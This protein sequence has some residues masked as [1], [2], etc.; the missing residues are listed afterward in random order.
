VKGEKMKHRGVL[1]IC[2]IVVVLAII[3]GCA[4]VP[5]VKKPDWVIKGSGAFPGE[6][7]TKIYGVGVAGTDPNK[8]VQ[9]EQARAR[10]RAELAA[11]ITTTVQRLVKD[12]ME[13]H[14]DWF[15]LEDTAGSDEFF[16]YISKQVTD[17]TLVGSRQVDSWEDPKTG[18]LYMLY[19]VDMDNSFYDSYKKAL[20][21]ALSEKHRAVVIK[22]VNEA[23]AEL[24][25][26]VEKQR[27]RED[28][29][30]G[31]PTETR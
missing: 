11:S 7:A 19:V 14:K 25:K 31:L 23:T 27:A 24:D 4:T 12:F 21:R 8:A 2:C 20:R 1:G 22:R 10:A 30:L 16:S 28:K 17:Q 15:N 18:D 26:E 29:I 13:T 9:I 6:P 5:K 3:I